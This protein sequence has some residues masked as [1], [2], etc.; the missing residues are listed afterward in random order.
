MSTRQKKSL[1][2]CCGQ[3]NYGEK[4]Y[5]LN[6][7]RTSQYACVWRCLIYLPLI[8]CL[9][10]AVLVTARRQIP[11]KDCVCSLLCFAA[12]TQLAE[13][14]PDPFSD[15]PCRYAFRSR[16][17]VRRRSIDVLH[18]AFCSDRP[19]YRICLCIYI[20]GSAPLGSLAVQEKCNS[21]CAA[22]RRE[23]HNRQAVTRLGRAALCC[24]GSS[25]LRGL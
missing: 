18:Y 17:H 5:C 7:G 15:R 19:P 16:S 4:T 8:C 11:P 23:L 2:E 6:T 12:F 3:G 10:A 9:S 1:S 20:T 25:G 22:K 24:C 13:L 21:S 14:L